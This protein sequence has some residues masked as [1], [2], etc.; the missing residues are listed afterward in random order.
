MRM[1]H[2]WIIACSETNEIVI[3]VN[4]MRCAGNKSNKTVDN[5]ISSK[6]HI[7]PLIQC[8]SSKFK[9]FEMYSLLLA[10]F[11]LENISAKDKT[12]RINLGSSL[13]C[14]FNGETI[15]DFSIFQFYF[16]FSTW[17]GLRIKKRAISS[18]KCQIIS[19]V[20]RKNCA[21]Y[22]HSEQLNWL[23]ITEAIHWNWNVSIL[24]KMPLWV[25]IDFESISL[26]DSL[27]EIWLVW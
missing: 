26:S 5:T 6:I 1:V 17:F 4:K 14:I 20:L 13:R 9:Q 16:Y 19:I 10:W 23:T 27:M 11:L 7:S 12:L 15:A 22:C 2:I 18:R 25:G 21:D 24:K 8:I 3:S